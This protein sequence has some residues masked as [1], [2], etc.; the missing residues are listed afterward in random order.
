MSGIAM[1][2]NYSH[3]TLEERCRL[4]GMTEMGL[5]VSEIAGR[6]GRHR[7]TVQRELA[8]N[9]CVDGYRPD[10]AERRAWARKLRGS[11]IARSTRLR[12][13]VE[14]RLAMGWSPEQIAGRMELEGSEH[15]VSAE[16]IYRHVYSPFGRQRN[17][18]GCSR[19]ASRSAAAGGATAAASPPSPSGCRSTSARQRPIFA[20]SSATGRATSCTSAVSAASC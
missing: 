10:S 3:L 13:H 19:S 6:L 17:C 15:R 5:S 18:P 2:K 4:R 20:A 11:K 16:S 14:D 8:R 12:D 9:R 7:S 1:G